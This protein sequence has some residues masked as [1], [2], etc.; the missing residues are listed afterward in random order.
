MRQWS[1]CKVE[2]VRLGNIVS[3]AVIGEW[4]DGSKNQTNITD[5]VVG[6]RPSGMGGNTS[7]FLDLRENGTIEVYQEQ[8]VEVYR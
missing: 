1:T 3:V 8:F 6:K 7:I 2:D 4:W 5:E